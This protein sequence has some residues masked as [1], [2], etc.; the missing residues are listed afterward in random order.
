MHRS[1]PDATR[2]ISQYRWPRPLFL[3]YGVR[4]QMGNRALRWLWAKALRFLDPKGRRSARVHRSVSRSLSLYPLW[5]AQ[6]MVVQWSLY[7]GRVRIPSHTLACHR[8][9]SSIVAR[10]P[11]SQRKASPNVLRISVCVLYVY[12]LISLILARIC[13]YPNLIYY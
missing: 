10:R 9:S 6:V 4:S 2:S 13:F 3:R 1:L 5:G 7:L 11:H 8:A 12:I